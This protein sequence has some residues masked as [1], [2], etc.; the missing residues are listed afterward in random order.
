MTMH[1]QTIYQLLDSRGP[2]GI[3]SHVLN[4]SC[5]LHE[6][7]FHNEVLFLEDHGSHPLKDA[8]DAEHIKWRCL[9][10]YSD[11]P[12]LLQ[13]SPSLLCTHGYKAGIFGR[14]IGWWYR[15]PVVSTY[16]S[17]D[18][19]RGRVWLYSQL[20]EA[21]AFLANKVICVS[22]E[23]AER[24]PVRSHKVANF[25]ANKVAPSTHGNAVAFVGRLSHEKDPHSFARV[26]R[27]LPLPC[28]VYGDGPLKNELQKAYSHLRFFGHVDMEKHWRAIGLLCITSRFEGLPLVALEAMIRGIP[29]VSYS[30]GELPNLIKNHQNGWLAPARNEKALRSIVKNWTDKSV[31]QKAA[32]AMRA[33]RHIIKF[34][35]DETICPQIVDLYEHAISQRRSTSPRK[36]GPT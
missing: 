8:L 20:D 21:T 4:L 12:K 30:V 33:H 13:Q 14:L 35:S 23:I 10:R 31:T 28:H 27:D 5:W 34:Y 16:H 7:G 17:G 18:R 22:H 6:N 24:L 25:V 26:T 9:A 11:L 29:V 2:G 1:Q 19:G 3:E 15:V 32:I 36:A